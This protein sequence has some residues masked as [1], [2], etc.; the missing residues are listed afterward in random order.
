MVKKRKRINKTRLTQEEMDSIV[1]FDEYN[2]L[3]T[4]E[5][6]NLDLQRRLLDTQYQLDAVNLANKKALFQKSLSDR[7]EVHKERMKLMASSRGIDDKWSFNPDSG[8]IIME[9]T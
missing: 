7:I 5:L 4:I 6:K 1:K 9:D 2:N 3:K 8:D